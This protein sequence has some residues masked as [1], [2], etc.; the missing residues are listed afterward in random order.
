MWIIAEKEFKELLYSPKFLIL[1]AVSAALIFISIFNGY[2][3][4]RSEMDEASISNKTNLDRLKENQSYDFL[5]IGVHRKPSVLSI[6]DSGISGVIGRKSSVMSAPPGVTV[7]RDGSNTWDARYTTD[8]VLALFGQLDLT[9]TVVILLSLFAFLLSYNSISG[10][11]ENGTLSQVFSTSITRSGVFLGKLVGGFIPLALMLIVPLLIGLVSLLLITQVHISPSG[12]IKIVLL[13]GSY[14]FYLLLFFVTGLTSST[15]SRNSF[16]SFMMCLLIWVISIAI[17]PKAAIQVAAQINPS[18]SIQEFKERQES[19]L[20]NLSKKFSKKRVDFI[21]AGKF[22]QE[23]WREKSREMNEKFRNEYQTELDNFKNNLSEEFKR[24]RV[25]LANTAVVLSRASPTACLSFTVHGLA[26]TGHRL[27]EDFE[28]SVARYGKSFDQFAE[29]LREKYAD[30]IEKERKSRRRSYEIKPDENGIMRVTVFT[31]EDER[32]TMNLEGMPQ[33]PGID[34]PVAA[35][36]SNAVFDLALIGVY[37]III[38]SLGFVVFLRY[39]VR[40][41]QN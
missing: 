16:V 31:Q 35:V 5:S 12:W 27:L 24:A 2:M 39:D 14:L 41:T 6:F 10:E 18:M 21:N 19:F 1:F 32:P 7:F 33:Y 30:E 28:E 40:W 3:N 9:F 36:V 34:L 15:L 37:T 23:T 8:P 4:Y 20:R 29:N 38:F 17:I 26:D 11:R 25:K 13:I 22:T